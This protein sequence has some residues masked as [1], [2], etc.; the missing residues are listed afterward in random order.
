MRRKFAWALA[1]LTLLGAAPVLSACNTT[2]GA[3]QDLQAAGKGISN[4][5]ATHKNY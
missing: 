2:E 5:A 4:E 3:G 1:I